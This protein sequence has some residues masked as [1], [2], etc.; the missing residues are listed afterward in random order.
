MSVVKID[1]TKVE[2][3]LKATY[4]RFQIQKSR[5]SVKPFK[6]KKISISILGRDEIPDLS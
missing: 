1:R 4:W 6:I 5:A 2:T 3:E